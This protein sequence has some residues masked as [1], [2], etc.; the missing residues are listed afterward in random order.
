MAVVTFGGDG[1]LEVSVDVSHSALATADRHDSH[2]DQ[3]F[4][5]GSVH[6]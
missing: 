1:K 3:R 6:H 5:G 2:A 4:V